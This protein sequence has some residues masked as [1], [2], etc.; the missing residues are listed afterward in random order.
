MGVVTSEGENREEGRKYEGLTSGGRGMADN[1]TVKIINALVE[2]SWLIV[3][4]RREGGSIGGRYD[5]L[6]SVRKGWSFNAGWGGGVRGGEKGV[7]YPALFILL[8]STKGGCV[9]IFMMRPR[10]SSH[11]PR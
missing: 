4:S 5:K 2:K 7:V 1:G 3:F 8:L 6:Q 11:R 9:H 10:T